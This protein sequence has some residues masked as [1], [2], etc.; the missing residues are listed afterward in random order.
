MKQPRKYPRSALDRIRG[1]GPRAGSGQ[2]GPRFV[3]QI[4]RRLPGSNRDPDRPRDLPCAIACAATIVTPRVCATYGNRVAVRSTVIVAF[5]AGGELTKRCHSPGNSWRKLNSLNSDGVAVPSP[6]S[7]L[8]D[9]GRR[10][11]QR[12]TAA[13]AVYR[14]CSQL[15]GH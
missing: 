8:T 7:Y 5:P 9:L 6:S 13:R 12:V 10:D 11:A 1:N 3:R 14:K 15:N 2:A 4:G